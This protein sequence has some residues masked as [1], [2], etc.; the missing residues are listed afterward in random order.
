ML[1]V[2]VLKSYR[3]AVQ[4]SACRRGRRMLT[5]CRVCVRLK[6]SSKLRYLISLLLVGVL[7]GST[8][9]CFRIKVPLLLK[10]A[11]EELYL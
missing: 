3:I 11:L 6:K 4:T 10:A 5:G 1:N 9:R 8:N 7:V 2:V